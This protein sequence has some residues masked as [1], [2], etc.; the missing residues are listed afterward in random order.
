MR[1]HKIVSFSVV[2]LLIT[3]LFAGAVTVATAPTDTMP[4]RSNAAYTGD[5]SPEA[6][7]TQPNNHLKWFDAANGTLATSP[8]IANDVVHVGSDDHNVDAIGKN[9]TTL[10]ASPSTST[11][12]AKQRFTIS[13]TLRSRNG[14]VPNVG[15]TLYRSPNNATWTKLRSATTTSGSTPGNYR[16]NVTENATGTLYYKVTYA[17]NATFSGSTAYAKVTVIKTQT[18]VTL[19]VSTT[20]PTINQKVAF[21]ATLKSGKMPLSGKS[22]TI[23]HYFNNAKY[24]DT[25]AKTN[26][27]GKITLT[28]RFG[29]AGQRP[30]YATFAGD[31]SYAS[32][33]GWLTITVKAE[34]TTET[35]YYVPQ[36]GS[37]W[38]NHGTAGARYNAYVS[39]PSI[40][41]TQSNGY[42]YW[43]GIGRNDFICV[44]AGSATNNQNVA[45]WEI[46]FRFAGIVPGE[47]YQKIWD[48]AYGGFFIEI[49][50]FYGPSK[51]Y[52]TIY[53][54]TTGGS[55]ARWYIPGDTVLR[56]GH[57]YYVQ[58][59][60]DTRAGPGNEPYP[61]VW[62]SEDGRAPVRQTH[63]DETGGA[64]NGSGAWYD[65]SVGPSSDLGNTSS[66]VPCG[67]NASAKTSW[68]VGGIF[69]YRQYNSIVSFSNGGHWNIDRPALTT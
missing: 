23:Y 49:D 24:T 10:T 2:I 1:V 48:K 66:N 64:L 60:W 19:T 44:P 35:L 36:A 42:P 47:R 28:Q 62:I 45:S 67:R 57:N 52:L 41:R 43:G 69:M 32:S 11:P 8:A 4:F 65:D 50:T 15:V 3:V 30:Y 56:V 53:R 58:I 21:T 13:G 38:V 34:P 26:S 63:W 55:G 68:L 40:Y 46:G 51:S 29:S 22:V 17:G 20:T 14:G 6:G 54:A 7:T 31:R 9:T 25:T 18:K 12:Q 33:T 16:F 61:T 27:A 39:T 5:Y 59:S 37:T